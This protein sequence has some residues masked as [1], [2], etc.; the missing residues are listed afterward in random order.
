MS[1]K[2][3]DE[4]F[5]LYTAWNMNVVEFADWVNHETYK[6]GQDEFD[7][8]YPSFNSAYKEYLKIIKGEYN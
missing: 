5:Q 1:Q 2:L 4:D 7:K 8:T 3:F 6:L